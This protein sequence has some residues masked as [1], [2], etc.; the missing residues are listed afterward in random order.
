MKNILLALFLVL[1]FTYV[2][3][4]EL[5]GIK[6]GEEDQY[7]HVV[8]NGCPEK[9]HNEKFVD[10]LSFEDAGVVVV[11]R[12]HIPGG[13]NQ[14]ST[15]ERI[16]ITSTSSAPVQD[17]CDTFKKYYPGLVTTITTHVGGIRQY[18]CAES[19]S[20]GPISLDVVGGPASLEVADQ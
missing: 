14:T 13:G 7:I 8:C 1:P 16:I 6:H 11:W 9:S 20:G 2:S 10:E 3:A 5:I 18:R 4:A 15:P 17:V 19:S 12:Q